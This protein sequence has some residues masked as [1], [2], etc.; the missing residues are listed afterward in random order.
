MVLWLPGEAGKGPRGWGR[1]GGG[2]GWAGEGYSDLVS[3]KQC[4]TLSAE[5]YLALK[6]HSS[7]VDFRTLMLHATLRAISLQI[8]VFSLRF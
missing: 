5:C 3:Q 7:C 6:Q 2:G 4:S 8:K 1:G